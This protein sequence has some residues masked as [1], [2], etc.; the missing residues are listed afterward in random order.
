MSIE[1]EIV[2]AKVHDDWERDSD[3][4]FMAAI[5][6]VRRDKGKALGYF[7]KGMRTWD[8]TGLRDRVNE[9]SGL[10]A[11]YKLTLSLSAAARLS[12]KPKERAKML[13]RLLA[14]QRQDGGFVTDDDAQGKLVGQ[15]NVETTALAILALDSEAGA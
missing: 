12:R 8:G 7:E 13:K 1:T 14:V 4:R 9:M 15:A 3:L 2:G 6:E 11:T 5:A 10:Y